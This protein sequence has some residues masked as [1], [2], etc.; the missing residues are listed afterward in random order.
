[1]QLGEELAVLVEV[2]SDVGV[3]FGF[4]R[5]L[6][7]FGCVL[8]VKLPPRLGSDVS[9]A[10]LGQEGSEDAPEPLALAGYAQHAMLW[11]VGEERRRVRRVAVKWLP[12]RP[13]A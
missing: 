3:Q 12:P 5:S 11:R 7:R 10:F 1:M 9:I 8:E 2:R 6:S 4:V 13:L